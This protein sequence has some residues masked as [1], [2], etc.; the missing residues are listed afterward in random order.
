MTPARTPVVL[1]ADAG[2]ALGVGHV[3]RS[4]VLGQALRARGFELVLVTR[5][6]PPSLAARARQ[7]GIEVVALDPKPD[8]PRDVAAMCELTPAFVMLDGYDL[9][10][11]YTRALGDARIPF[12]VVDDNREVPLDGAS[13]VVNHNPHAST[14]MYH[15]VDPSTQLLLGPRYALL[16]D[17]LAGVRSQRPSHA[18]EGAAESGAAYRIVVAF[19][20]SDPRR[21]TLPVVA[22]LAREPRIEF[23]VAAGLANPCR[24]EIAA[25]CCALGPR[26]ALD[27]GDLTESFAWADLAVVGAGTT[28]WETAYVALPCVAVV[29]ADNQVHAAAAAAGMGIVAFV[30]ARE[31]FPVAAIAATARRLL[32]DPERRARMAACGLA[33]FDGEGAGRVADA[34]ATRVGVAV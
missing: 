29:V 1:R 24:D 34:I 2:G 8:I 31:D 21:L 12:G 14:A 20:G 4:L 22:A 3:M 16:R 23:R 32:D 26:A 10:A 27:P 6:L 15:G 33:T 17:D 18:G 5:A 11:P 30:D 9:G 7:L 19:G 25:V 13:I 28:A